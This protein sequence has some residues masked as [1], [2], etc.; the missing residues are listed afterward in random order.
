[1]ASDSSTL[2]VGASPDQTMLQQKALAVYTEALNE[3]MEPLAPYYQQALAKLVEIQQ[4]YTVE[5]SRRITMAYQTYAQALAGLSIG[6]THYEKTVNAQNALAMRYGEYIDPA[7]WAD[8]FAPA[9]QRL[10]SAYA[11]ALQ[12][13]DANGALQQAIASYYQD[14]NDA[15]QDD[16]L[17][18]ELT[19]AQAHYFE[20]ATALQADI[21]RDWQEAVETVGED[22]ADAASQTADAFDVNTA[23]EDF[24]AA[25]E[26]IS[27]KITDAY[28]TAA[29][30]ATEVWD[31]GGASVAPP[32]ERPAKPASPAGP[33]AA[34]GASFVANP[35]P[36][37]A[38]SKRPTPPDTKK[39]AKA[40]SVGTAT[41]PRASWVNVPERSDK[42]PAAKTPAKEAR[43]T[44]SPKPARKS[45]RK[46]AKPKPAGS[47]AKDNGGE[48]KKD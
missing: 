10:E 42:A 30:T 41:A 22:L 6:S 4:G 19:D 5:L 40:M 33:A 36:K 15:L 20:Q 26:E 14:L 25:L 28:E 8:L 46:A 11:D 35:R 43:K 12:S 44:A 2:G 37:P 39:A 34:G 45:P 7:R 3:A 31:D 23:L 18:Q 38:P 1:M 48:A 32:P 17:V 24:G 29:K 27:Q 13:D 21:E 47:K 16:P 9:Q